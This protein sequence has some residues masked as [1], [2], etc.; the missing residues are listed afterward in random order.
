MASFTVL[1]DELAPIGRTETGGYRRFAWT[2][3][4][5]TLRAWF[6][7][8]CEQRGLDY[9]EDSVGN[10]WGWWGGPGPGAIVSGSHLDSVPDG[11]AFDGPLGVVSALLAVDELRRRGMRPRRP[12]AV[13]NFVDE[14][15]AR[16]GV[17]CSGSRVLT[18]VLSP[19]RAL[20]LRD[21]DG[22]TMAEALRRC[23]RDPETFGPDPGLVSS[24]AAFVEVHVEQGRALADLADEPIAVATS[25]WPHGRWRI[26]LPGEANH[27]GTTRLPDRRDAMLAAAEVTLAARRAAQR[28]GAVAT[29]G[30]VE[31]TPNGINAIPS[32]VRCWLDARAPDPAAVFAVVEDVSGVVSGLGGEIACQSWTDDTPF[33]PWL[34]D[35]LHLRLGEPPLLGTGAGHD[36]AVLASVGVPAGMLFVRNPTGHSHSPAETASVPDCERGVLALADVLEDL[37]MAESLP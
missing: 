4:D 18:G 36:A 2:P 11:G 23:G 9:R 3:E 7:S 14:E 10:Q 31:V 13:V 20:G 33:T 21:D 12:V 15:G 28:H 24:I 17:A 8:Q 35:R 30:K 5:L 32:H 34:R 1:W 29:I 37:V 27:A 22:L 6:Q 26:E 25:V 16:F 19:E